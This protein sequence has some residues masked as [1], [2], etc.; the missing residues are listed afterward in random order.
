VFELITRVSNLSL[1][2]RPMMLDHLG[3]LDTF[4]WYLGRYTAIT[5]VQVDFKHFGLGELIK[6][7]VAITVYRV[8]QEALTNVARHAGVDRAAVNIWVDRDRIYLRVEDKG[9]GFDPGAVD[10]TASSGISGMHE[11]VSLMGGSLSI[12]SAPGTGALVSAEIPLGSARG[13]KKE[14]A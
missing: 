9:S 7:E 13:D 2:L 14:T 5:R 1:D 3:L 12:K 11:R 4:M 6:P 8:V 10:S